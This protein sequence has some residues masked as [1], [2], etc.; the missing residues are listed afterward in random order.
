[1]LC[2]GIAYIPR[3]TGRDGIDAAHWDFYIAYNLFRIAAILQGIMKRYVDG[4]ASSAQALESGKTYKVAVERD[5]QTLRMFLD[6]KL[7]DDLPAVLERA[8]S[9][10]RFSR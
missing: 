4:T 5:G 9:A 2:H 7:V 10:E 1:M 3:L 8:R 6:D